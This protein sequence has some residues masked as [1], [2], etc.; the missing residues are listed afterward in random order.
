MITA[1][2][3]M[4]TDGTAEA[5]V[6]V[7]LAEEANLKR[8]ARRL[9]RCESD[10]D[11]LVQETLLRAF[12]ARDRFLP[13]TSVRAWTTTILR[14]VFLT[15]AIRT[16][17]RG[18]VTETACGETFEV[19]EDRS[20]SWPNDVEPTLE[21]LIS[22]LDDP[23]R[24]ALERVPVLYR[25]A[26]C[27]SVIQELSCAEIAA[28]LRVPKGTAMSRVHRARES[29]RRDLG[30]PHALEGSDYGDNRRS[31]GPSVTKAFAP[32]LVRGPRKLRKAAG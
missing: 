22:T 11:D 29:L 1:E 23:F 18:M 26:F 8:F 14:R 3:E 6:D 20:Q 24:W 28:K 13:G 9:V 15:G 16:R 2:M 27:M 17:R 31:S 12:R 30:A 4:A 7:I 25:Q 5:T 19:A 10:A 21:A 32:T